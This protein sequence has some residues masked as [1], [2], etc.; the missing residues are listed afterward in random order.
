MFKQFD[1]ECETCSHEFLDM[2]EGVEG[3]PECC[4]SCGVRSGFKKL[5]SL[6]S[7]PRKIIVD[8]PGSKRFKAGYVHTHA[9][10]PAEKA[11][12]QVSMRGTGGVVKE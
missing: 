2:V 10:R 4:P 11:S 5:I 9:D 8:Y 12:S 3:Q 1:F 7:I 6:P